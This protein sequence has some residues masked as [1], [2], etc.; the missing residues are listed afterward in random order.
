MPFPRIFAPV[1]VALITGALLGCA[2]TEGDRP[3]A[4]PADQDSDWSQYLRPADDHVQISVQG[5]PA[6]N[7]G[8]ATDL[9]VDIDPKEAHVYHGAE[10]RW[11]T[12]GDNAMIQVRRR[13][14]GA[15]WPFQE[16]QFPEVAG[17]QP[18]PAG[19]ADQAEVASR[20]QYD[21]IVRCGNMRVTIDPEVII[22][23]P[24]HRLTED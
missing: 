9:Q 6:P 17:G 11:E 23:D 10:F 7:Q 14:Q 13:P 8:P 22:R 21:V 24:N 16:A 19:R 1:A 15:T 3:A 18:I 5:C 12:S 20:S 2:D 4:A